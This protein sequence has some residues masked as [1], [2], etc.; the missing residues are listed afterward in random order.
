MARPPKSY[1]L[2][3]AGICVKMLFTLL[4]A[5]V[6]F[7]MIWRVFISANPPAAMDRL[8]PNEALAAAYRTHGDELEL[9][10]QKQP[11]ITKGDDNYGYFGVTHF[12][13]IPEAQQLQLTLRYNNSTLKYTKEALGLSD[14]PPRGEEIF[15]ASVVQVVDL[16]PDDLADN[17]DDSLMLQKVRHTPTAHIIDTT[18]LYTY[19]LYTFD[20]ITISD[21]TITAYLDVYYGLEPDYATPAFGT[22]RLYHRE[23]PKLEVKLTSKEEK[24]LK[25]YGN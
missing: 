1:A 5:A 3:I 14:I 10:N 23:D 6:C 25:E 21:D 19:V 4:I 9:Y 22:L 20:G 24:L 18:A 13:F 12:V 17:T 11:S 15:D 7:F 8:V 16:T 2:W